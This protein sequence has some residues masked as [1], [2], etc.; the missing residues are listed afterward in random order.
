MDAKVKTRVTQAH[1]FVVVNLPATL[2]HR[3]DQND[4]SESPSFIALNCIKSGVY[5]ANRL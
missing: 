5:S 2:N 1:F 3:P 4:A